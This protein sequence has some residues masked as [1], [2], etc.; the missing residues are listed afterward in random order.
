MAT[1]STIVGIFDDQGRAQN[2][3]KELKQRGFTESQIGVVGRHYEAGDAGNTRA[4]GD[5]N[6]DS[7]AGEGAAAGLATG[8]GVG[9]LWGLG[10]LAGALP[11]IGP[12]IAGGTL[13]AILSSAAAGAAAAGLAGGLVGM[14]ISKE[15]ADYYESE[16]KAGRTII[17][18]NA[19]GREDE[20]RQV[21]STLGA[22]DVSRRG[23]SQATS[24]ARMRGQAGPVVG[25]QAGW[26]EAH[27]STVNR[28]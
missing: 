18:V 22:Y 17:T 14:G 15:D 7:Y 10:I 13:A 16:F 6:D 21:F 28:R 3:V 25:E 9:A 26:V 11:A 24:D 1:S 20:V 8:A 5:A 27:D 23:A 2:A 19:A 12:A 4:L